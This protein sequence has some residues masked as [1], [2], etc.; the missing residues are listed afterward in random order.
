MYP[1]AF[2]RRKLEEKRYR[3]I[4]EALSMER[5]RKTGE[6]IQPVD[7]RRQRAI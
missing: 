1:D 2:R 7:G 6:D 4:R 5:T 3:S